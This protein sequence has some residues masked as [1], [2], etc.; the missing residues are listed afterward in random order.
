MTQHD[1]SAPGNAVNRT[2]IAEIGSELG[3]IMARL[4]E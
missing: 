2:D 1:C 4:V 3:G